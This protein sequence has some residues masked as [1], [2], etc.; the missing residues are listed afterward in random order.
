MS[1]IR[2]G[3]IGCGR[4][5]RV[6]AAN[7]VAHPRLELAA[8][9]DSLRE[10][11]DSLA[12]AHGAKLARS[13]EE[14][15]ESGQVDG[16]LVASSSSTHADYIEQAVAAK[17]PVLCEKPIDLDIRRVNACGAAIAGSDVPV[18]IGFNRRFDPGHAAARNALLSGRIG[19]LRQ[20]VIS[21][22]DPEP[23]PVKFLSASGGLLRSMTIHDF[24]LA[25]YMLADEPVEVFAAMNRL[26]APGMMKE[27]DDHDTAMVFMRTASGVQCHINNCRQAAFGYDQRV[28]LFGSAGMAVSGNRKPHE[29]HVHSSDSTD[30]SEPYLHFFIERYSEAYMGELTAFADCIANGTPASPSFE[31]GRHALLLAEAASLS[32]REGRAVKISEVC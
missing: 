5:G 22:R 8:V 1:A 27:H 10:A 28:E 25:R 21:S 17:K 29:A 12:A 15:F 31:D 30:A 9:F 32:A 11:A 6:H 16:V 2:I 7:I 4:I 23:P 3:L 13:A 24:D 14:L 18:Q 26:V 20:V 19:D